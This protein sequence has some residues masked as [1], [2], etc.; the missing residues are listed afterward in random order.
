MPIEPDGTFSVRSRGD[1]LSRLVEGLRE[2]W[3]EDV[4][5]D[6]NAP[7]VKILEAALVLPMFETQDDL[8]DLYRQM[9]PSGAIGNNL[10]NHLEFLG[11]E[12][13]VATRATGTVQLSFTDIPDSPSPFFE[14]DDLTFRSSDGQ[15]F[16]LTSSVSLPGNVIDI[17]ETGTNSEAVN[18]TN[19]KL[20]QKFTL[21]EEQLVDGWQLKA[22][23][24][25]GTP[26]YTIRIEGHDSENDQPDGNLADSNLEETGWEPADDSVDTGA[27]PEAVQLS[28]GTYWFVIVHE[29]DSSDFDGGTGGTADQVKFFD[30]TWN[31]STNVEN[32]NIE[33][34]EGGKAEVEAQNLGAGGNIPSG[35]IDTVEFQNSTV[36]A[37]WNDNIQD[38]D[39]LDSFSGGQNK[40]SDAQCR[41]RVRQQLA[42]RP[43]SSLDGLVAAVDSV[44]GVSDVDGIENTTDTGGEEDT[45]AFSD[46]TGTASESVD[47]ATAERMAM[48]LD[49]QHRRW[50][51][52]FN[53]QLASDSDLVTTVRLE[54]NDSGNN[55][56]DGTLAHSNLDLSGFDFD[57]TN[58]TSGTWQ[59]GGYVDAGSYWL[60]FE[61]ESGSGDFDGSLNETDITNGGFE[62]YSTSPGAPDDW[63]TFGSSLTVREENTNVRT[64]SNAV[65]IES[66]DSAGDPKGIEQK[67]PDPAT[68]ESVRKRVRVH[69]RTDGDSGEVPTLAIYNA[70]DDT[71]VDSTSGTDGGTSYEQL[72]LFFTPDPDKEYF[73][74]LMHASGD[75]SSNDVI[76]FDDAS[77]TEKSVKNFDGSNWV[78]DSNV[79]LIN[80]DLIGGVPPKGFRIFARGGAEDDI[81]QELWEVHSAG[82]GV[83]GADSGTAT[84]RSGDDHTMHFERPTDVEVFVEIAVTKDTNDFRGDE[85]TIRDII[86]EYVGG[87]DTNDDD[88]EGLGFGDDVVRNEIIGAVLDDDNVQG[89]IDV[90][91]LTLSTTNNPPN[92][93]ETSNLTPE[94][95]ERFTISDP[96]APADGGNITVTLNDA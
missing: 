5:L 71:T 18:S 37:R 63:S 96:S 79:D 42:S 33:V 10:D 66:T 36:S 50:I 77:V 85:D 11:Y 52:H 12:R 1:L 25:S 73:I 95:G 23:H 55:E 4:D 80:A 56:P 48:R 35:A 32:L 92:S 72:Q 15:R 65:E 90:T 8:A 7:P 22:I 53:A 61:R 89:T 49:L 41:E 38:F 14:Q 84:D 58:D 59:D 76:Y 24:N 83:D 39:N 16:D 31:L 93:G 2:E 40:E 62:T 9:F 87:T 3:G 28:S 60:V 6:P 43:M 13:E 75:A 29:Q 26:R 54:N 30:G 86:V 88:F 74:R 69:A 67:I 70:T 44:D 17:N 68:V 94:T 34:I 51:Q 45:V 20:A 64:G 78:D 21:D 57:G 47:G 46:S 27:F 81:A 91:T 82:I 19:T